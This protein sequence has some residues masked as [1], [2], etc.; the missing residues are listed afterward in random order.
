MVA[1]DRQ[2]IDGIGP[3]DLIPAPWMV[4]AACTGADPDLFFGEAGS[5]SK[6]AKEICR[7]C[8]VRDDCLEF[9]LQ[10]S[11]RFGIWGGLTFKQRL[12]FQQDRV[13]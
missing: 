13:A 3:R 11:E 5:P 9:A 7:S 12:R 6:E 8:V 1:P 10:L 4:H 2:L